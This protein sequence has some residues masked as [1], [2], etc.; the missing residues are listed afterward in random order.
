MT[1]PETL[2]ASDALSA[3]ALPAAVVPSAL[4]RARWL[5]YQYALDLTLF[6]PQLWIRATAGGKQ[7][8]FDPSQLP[9][10]ADMEAAYPEIL[11]EY[12]KISEQRLPSYQDIEEVNTQINTDDQWKTYFLHYYGY[13]IAKAER[14][15]PAT[16]SALRRIPGLQFAMFSILAPGKRIPAH[17]G[18]YA[19]VLRYHLGV[20]VPEGCVLRIDGERR[21]WENGKSLVFDDS[22]EHEVWN[23]SERQRCVL[24][25]DVERPLPGLLGKLNR[26]LLA[27]SAST[28]IAKDSAKNLAIW[29]QAQEP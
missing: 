4:R 14:E 26:W 20:D 5:F 2:S 25:V 15:C 19:G 8:F 11:A 3:P 10:V 23:H 17:K 6:F 16:V 21:S 27:Q 12:R 28:Q 29:Q 9:W 24:F 13:R 7:R 22:Y 1:A 18:P